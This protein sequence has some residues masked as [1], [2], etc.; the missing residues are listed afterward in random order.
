MMEKTKE[1]REKTEKQHEND[2]EGP[3]VYNKRQLIHL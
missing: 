1:Q 2:S 3:D